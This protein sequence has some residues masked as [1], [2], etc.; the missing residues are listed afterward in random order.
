M[1]SV[2]SDANIIIDLAAGD[3]LP[4]MFRI[5]EVTFF[6]PDV[7][8]EEELSD[9]YAQLPG[10]G[11][12][13][14]SQSSLATEYV[15]RL[16]RQYARP[17]TNDLFALALARDMGCPLLTGDRALREAAGVEHVEVHGT[18]WV[19][20]AMWDAGLITVERAQA[21]YEAMRAHNSRL[22]WEQVEAQ[23]ERWRRN[24]G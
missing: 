4:D 8:Y 5:P 15:E 19:M 14:R 20:E 17:S 11:L 12:Q 16:R 10:L 22:P 1:Q 3:L 6:V 18:L 21:A 24:A 23:L 9:Q 2:V 7:L 13:V